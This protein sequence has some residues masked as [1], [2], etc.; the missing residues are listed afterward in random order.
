MRPHCI[1]RKVDAFF[2]ENLIVENIAD[3]PPG[4]QRDGRI[5]IRQC[6][7]LRVN[8]PTVTGIRG[9]WTG[10]N[11]RLF[12]IIGAEWWNGFHASREA[13]RVCLTKT[14]VAIPDNYNTLKLAPQRVCDIEDGKL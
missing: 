14:G 6:D 5:W 2:D 8:L 10:T 9:T 12:L 1:M 3:N 7:F 13:I 11:S 4:I